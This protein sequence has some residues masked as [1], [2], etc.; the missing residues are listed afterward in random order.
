MSD[1]GNQEK[2]KYLIFLQRDEKTKSY[3]VI[4][5]LTYENIIDMSDKNNYENFRT[6][7]NIALKIYT[8]INSIDAINN[9]NRIN[10]NIVKNI[11][12][13]IENNIENDIENDIIILFE[14]NFGKNILK[15]V[16]FIKKEEK[17]DFINIFPI[18]ITNNNFEFGNIIKLSAHEYNNKFNIK[19]NDNLIQKFNPINQF[20]NLEKNKYNKII[21]TI[22]S[23]ELN[24]GDIQLSDKDILSSDSYENID[25]RYKVSK[26]NA[27]I[28]I[29]SSCY[30]GISFIEL[31]QHNV[32]KPKEAL[33]N[34]FLEN[35]QLNNYS[36]TN[37]TVSS[38][39]T[40]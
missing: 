1:T 29:K 23:H 8:K 25:C 35:K 36:K 17:T 7:K 31:N 26:S 13:N 24:M 5:I 6:F 39:R 16:I 22:K 18:S 15:D 9:I 10:S 34:N 33:I 4:N 19:K 27:M 21:E 3:D 14:K 40:V 38:N 2:S 32:N 12:N 20:L 11:S 37:S 28:Q 30:E